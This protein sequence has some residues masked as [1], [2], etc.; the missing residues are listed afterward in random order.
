MHTVKIN[1]LIF[2]YF[3]VN[4]NGAIS[5]TRA[6]S[7]FTPDPFPLNSTQDIIAAY[8]GDVDTRPA[9]GGTVWYRETSNS[10]LLSRFRDEIRAAFPNQREFIPTSLFIVTWDHVGYY[11]QNTDKVCSLP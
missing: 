2:P 8:W 6:I 7:Q 3:Q 4:N 10:L 1:L 5:F 9:D 11:R